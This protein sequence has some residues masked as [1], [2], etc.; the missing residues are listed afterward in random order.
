MAISQLPHRK[1]IR[2]NGKK[3]GRFYLIST[4]LSRK[5]SVP[6]SQLY[7]PTPEEEA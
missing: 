3:M 4:P 7:H 1:E 5:Q 6:F 2:T